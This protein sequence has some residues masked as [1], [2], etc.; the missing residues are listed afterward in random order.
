MITPS[1]VEKIRAEFPMLSTKVHGHPLVYL[2]NAAT[3]HKPRAVIERIRQFES[4][5]YATVRRGSYT[6]GEEA[7]EMFEGVRKKVQ[8]FIGAKDHR[9][10]IFT[11]GATQSINLVA[12]SFGRT[13]IGAGDEI[14]ISHMEH[15]A[16]LVPWQLLC[17]EKGCVLKVIPVSDSGELEM[18][19]FKKLLGP[20]TKLVAVTHS[21]NVLG[22]I[23]PV[24]EIA[25]LAHAAG[26][27][28]L[29]DGAQSV[30]HTKIDVQDIDCDFL[31]FS[32]HKMYGPSGVGVL[33][34]KYAVL[35]TMP[36][37]VAGGDMINSV[38]IER[39]TFAKPPGR[40][41]A[42]TPP[43]SQVIGLGAAVDFLTGI[44]MERIFEYE[45]S[46]LEYGTKVLSGIEGLRIIGTAPHKA[47]IISFWLEAAHPHDVITI[48]DREGIA[49]RGGHHCA[50]PVMARFG[51]PATTRASLSFYNKPEEID[52]LAGAL[53][54]VIQ[55]FG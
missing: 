49:V 45:K 33:Y 43:I 51:V 2:D 20:K 54:K 19:A 12:N 16:N 11:S 18:E 37:Y 21:S 42:G 52:L 53:K 14:V 9:E 4:E 39:T 29:V 47:A 32:S 24:K 27:K 31:A 1:E 35:E 6:L 34:G 26:A 22:T 8:V 15:H 10:I 7:T 17:L 41:E 3:T 55:V 28:V 50:Q 48:I 38:T 40:F 5:Q 44:G 13:F 30:P 36:P 25:R 46:L 23:N